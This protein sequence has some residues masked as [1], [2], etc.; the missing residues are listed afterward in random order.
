MLLAR[1]PLLSLVVASLALA[2]AAP[3]EQTV[4]VEGEA[5]I[6]G[7]NALGAKDKAIEVALRRAVEQVCGALVSATTLVEKS[8]L[9][10]DR[11]YTQAR[12]YVSKYELLPGGGESKGVY[13][14]KVKA[15]VGTGKLSDDLGAIGLTLARKGLPR[16]AVLIV[17]QRI[18]D[19]V[20]VAWWTEAGR[21][22][23]HAT[24]SQ[25]ITESTLLEGWLKAGFTFVDPET[26]AS[27]ARVAGVLDGQLGES[28]ARQLGD[29]LS[30]A[31][32]IIVGNALAKKAGDLKDL[33]G[34]SH[35]AK[36]LKGISCTGTVTLRVL[37]ADNAAE[38]LAAGEESKTVSQLDGLT[39]GRAALV[40]AT[41][42]L[43]ARLQKDVIAKWNSQL[44]NGTRVRV[45]FTGVDSV[46]T[47]TKLKGALAQQV[48]GASVTGSPRFAAGKADFDVLLKGA[49]EEAAEQLEAWKV[50]GKKI[51]VTSMTANTI[52]AE[53]AR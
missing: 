17:E 16:V 14:V 1:L 22:A 46:G 9:V 11:I 53:I 10:E 29:K 32:V 34:D 12:G 30:E 40:E 7:G 43:S 49:V 44:A 51:K 38:V 36:D 52:A 20:P 28:A 5:A 2:Q 45:T 8:Q 23:G 15:T 6:V 33:V 39:C 48:R 27:G 42:S 41:K 4:E 18:D 24:V 47:F 50:A 19:S 35:G 25:R 26:V 31:D 13:T 3:A 37:N 21:K